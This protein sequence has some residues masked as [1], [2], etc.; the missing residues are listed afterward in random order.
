MLEPTLDG[1]RWL[2]CLI[3]DDPIVLQILVGHNSLVESMKELV[4]TTR[5]RDTK[6]P[7]ALE[8]YKASVI[9]KWRLA[10]SVTPTPHR[11]TLISKLTM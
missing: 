2:N 6:D 1:S 11:S 9:A 4:K 5:A 8:L 3:E 10:Y 7:H